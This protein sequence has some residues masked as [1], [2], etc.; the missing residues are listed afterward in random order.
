MIK[1]GSFR[2]WVVSGIGTTNTNKG[3][4]RVVQMTEAALG[5]LGNGNVKDK[6]SMEK[7]VEP[8]GVEKFVG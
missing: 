5:I 3:Q 7:Q 6:R 8:N 4:R 2:R 1:S